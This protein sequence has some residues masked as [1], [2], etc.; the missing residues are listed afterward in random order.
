MDVIRESMNRLLSLFLV[1][2]ALPLAALAQQQGT[3]PA[4]RPE[5]LSELDA[6]IT[7]AIADGKCPGGVLWLEH[8]GTAYHRAYGNRCVEPTAEAMS[9]E[10]IFDAAS[11]TKVVATTTAVMLLVET[12][13]VK[14]AEKVR[15]YLPE[16]TGD[17]REEI[18][19]RQLLTHTSGLRPD[20]PPGGPPG[21]EVTLGRVFRERP[22]AAP[23]TAF[24]YSDLNFIL[25]GAVVAR[26]SGMPLDQF[27]AERIFGPLKMSDT[28]FHPPVALQGRIAPTTRE[29][30][31]GMVHDPTAQLM[32][33]VAGHAGLFATAADLARFAR[34][35][36]GHGSLESVRL[37]QPETVQ[38][39]TT[40]QSPPGLADR[41]GL[42]WDIDSRFASPRGTVFPIGSYGHTGWTGGSL[43]IDP[44]SETFVIFLSNRNH[45][46]EA[47]SVTELRKVIGTLAAEAAGRGE[48]ESGSGSGK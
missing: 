33:G 26:V 30:P 34:M 37:L 2:C 44:T 4:F 18:T 22:T 27:C 36:L 1:L 40:V 39:M 19:V 13:Q 45:P 12:Q 29:T 32:G 31:R 35:L 41:R 16:F 11:L 25:L 48:K 14:L 7:Q 15:T 47:G 42:G 46:T 24:R 28:L 3:A 43:W 10:T 20:L 23:D 8:A 9:E 21:Y 5:K 17:G 38:L 6:A